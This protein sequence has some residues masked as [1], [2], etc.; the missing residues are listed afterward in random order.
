MV[1]LQILGL[2]VGALSALIGFSTGVFDLTNPYLFGV[3]GAYVKLM[4]S[5][6]L[7]D[8]QAIWYLLRFTRGD[9]AKYDSLKEFADYGMMR[10]WKEV[11]RMKLEP[12]KIDQ[13]EDKLFAFTHPIY[14]YN[15]N[16][17]ECMV[18]GL[19]EFA[20]LYSNCL[21]SLQRRTAFFVLSISFLIQVLAIFMRW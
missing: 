5:R 10:R 13:R 15:K 16:G 12:G 7:T 1:Y 20:Y 14:G 21:R 2:A 19:R 6:E 18:V 17:D 9:L 11:V 4:A 8:R 3:S